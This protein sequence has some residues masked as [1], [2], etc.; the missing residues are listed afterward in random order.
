MNDNTNSTRQEIV[1]KDESN[2]TWK[3]EIKTK[4]I[5]I[6]VD[7]GVNSTVYQ[8]LNELFEKANEQEEKFKKQANELDFIKK[9]SKETVIS[10]KIEAKEYSEKIKKELDLWRIITMGV[11]IVTVIGF[12][13]LIVDTFWSRNNDFNKMNLEYN[14]RVND[15]ENKINITELEKNDLEKKIVE[16]KVILENYKKQQSCLAGK[17]Y[18]EYEQCFK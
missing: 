5:S 9:E 12:V 11:T 3:D 6:E 8:V 2:S 4:M 13:T 16:Q 1:K 17:K 18:W 14:D 7:L 15:L 10:L